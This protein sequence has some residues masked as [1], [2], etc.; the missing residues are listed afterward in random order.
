MAQQSP[1][2]KDCEK[3]RIGCHAQCQEYK[4]WKQ[5]QDEIRDARNE[6]NRTTP[7]WPR[8]V[9]RYVWRQQRWSRR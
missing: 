7:T 3:R 9:L 2:H 8:N 6:Q 5:K 4:E 1:C